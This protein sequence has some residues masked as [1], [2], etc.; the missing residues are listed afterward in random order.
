LV[1]RADFLIEPR[2][3]RSWRLGAAQLIDCLADREFI[4]FSH[5]KILGR[6]SRRREV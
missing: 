4:D 3:P 5:R 6:Q 1:K 2:H